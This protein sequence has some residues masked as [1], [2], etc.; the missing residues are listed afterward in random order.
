MS[1]N[2]GFMPSGTSE[3]SYLQR[4]G[5]VGGRLAGLAVSLT[6]SSQH[7]GRQIHRGAPVLTALQG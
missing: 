1:A 6:V 7:P 2:M 4:V 3:A 5:G